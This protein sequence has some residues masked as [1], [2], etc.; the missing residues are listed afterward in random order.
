MGAE[1]VPPLSRLATQ[2]LERTPMHLALIYVL[3]IAAALL[4]PALVAL[5]TFHAA[6]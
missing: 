1:N 2:P 4:A 5:A 3:V 6:R